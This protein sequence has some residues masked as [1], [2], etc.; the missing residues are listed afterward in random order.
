[1]PWQMQSQFLTQFPALKRWFNEIAV[2][3]ATLRTYAQAAAFQN[4]AVVAECSRQLLFGQTAA[5]HLLIT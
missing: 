2:R 1:V 5:S 3:P 4:P